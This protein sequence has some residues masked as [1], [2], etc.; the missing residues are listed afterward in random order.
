MHKCL[1]K[2]EDQRVSGIQRDGHFHARNEILLCI[3][4]RNPVNSGSATKGVTRVERSP[5]SVGERVAE[6]SFEPR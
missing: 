3:V 5:N 1:G 4:L 2:L 6:M